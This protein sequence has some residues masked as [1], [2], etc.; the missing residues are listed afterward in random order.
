MRIIYV[1]LALVC[2]ALAGCSDDVDVDLGQ[3]G[4]G[5]NGNGGGGDA[6]NLSTLVIQ[7]C[8]QMPEDRDPTSIN[9]LAFA[10]GANDPNNQTF[11][12]NCL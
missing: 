11:T 2:L 9:G 8:N 3:N 10:P 6:V 7:E 5:G 4:G 12:N 1:M